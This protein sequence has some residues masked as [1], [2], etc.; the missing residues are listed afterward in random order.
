MEI[1]R[2]QSHEK[3]LRFKKLFSYINHK[4][5]LS[6]GCKLPCWCYA[7]FTRSLRYR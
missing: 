2:L 4:L 5:W 7:R 1:A 6:G 3:I